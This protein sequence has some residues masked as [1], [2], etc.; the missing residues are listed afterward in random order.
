[1]KSILQQ[2]KHCWVCGNPYTEEHHV[3]YGT[4]KRE[5]S[6]KYG[7]KVYLCYIHHRGKDGVHSGNKTLDIA[8]KKY[9][10][11]QFEKTHSREEFIQIF[12]RNY[13]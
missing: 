11:I 5:L 2:N 7:L 3:I 13:L 12:R 9:A 10:Q 1:M 6:E 4:G 8:L